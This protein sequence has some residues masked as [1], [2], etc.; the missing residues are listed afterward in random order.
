MNIRLKSFALAA[1]LITAI[2]TAPAVFANEN[3][4]AL[5]SMMNQDGTIRGGKMGPGG[6]M[7]MMGQM[8]EMMETCTNMMKGAMN[9]QGTGTSK[10]PAQGSGSN[11]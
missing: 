1:A 3:S 8:N 9:D 5:G 7:G 2:A 11:Q 4:N 10:N 6:M